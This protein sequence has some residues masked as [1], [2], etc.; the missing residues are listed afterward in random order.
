MR[1]P[2]ERQTGEGACGL[3]PGARS[4]G[5]GAAS[6][7]ASASHL[8]V[9]EINTDTG[10]GLQGS[11]CWGQP[12]EGRIKLPGFKCELHHSTHSVTPD[13][14]LTFQSLWFPITHPRI[15]IGPISQGSSR[16]H[17]QKVQ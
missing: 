10:S 2:F 12:A 6:C 13:K 16:N 5:P 17:S 1:P 14:S 11:V 7:N 15:I 4:A 3:G 8:E 9:E